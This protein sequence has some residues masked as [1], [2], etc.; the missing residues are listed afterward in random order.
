MKSQIKAAGDISAL[1]DKNGR[2]VFEQDEIE[3]VVLD[4]F[5]KIFGAQRWPVYPVDNPPDQIELSLLELSK[6]ICQ[7]NPSFKEDE[8]EEKV[9]CKYTYLGLEKTLNDLP[10]GK[11]SGYDKISNE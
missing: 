11:A 3:E 8:F 7:T 10:V 9:C 5:S 6:I 2:M 4:H 1:D